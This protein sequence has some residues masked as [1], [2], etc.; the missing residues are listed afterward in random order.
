M[1]DPHATECDHPIGG[2]LTITVV[3]PTNDTRPTRAASPRAQDDPHARRP[4]DEE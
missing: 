3:V 4:G 2:F 1:P